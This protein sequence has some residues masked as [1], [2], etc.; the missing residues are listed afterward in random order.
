MIL[1]ISSQGIFFEKQGCRSKRKL[2]ACGRGVGQRE[3]ILD[4]RVTKI[5]GHPDLI[6]WIFLSSLYI[7]L[8]NI[9]FY[10]IC[11]FDESEAICCLGS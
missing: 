8:N 9:L 7:Y 1:N 10:F 5:M 2:Y 6:L 11:I 4:F 3:E